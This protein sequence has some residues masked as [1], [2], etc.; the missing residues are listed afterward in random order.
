MCAD[1]HRLTFCSTLLGSVFLHLASNGSS[2]EVRRSTLTVLSTLA[3]KQPELVNHLVSSALTTRLS[4][5]APTRAAVNSDDVEI[6]TT[7]PES[8]F[9]PFLL[10]CSAFGDTVDQ[11]TREPLLVNLVV[12]GHH[13]A[14]GESLI[15]IH[16][17]LDSG[18]CSSIS[19]LRIK[20]T[21]D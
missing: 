6:K 1:N 18:N 2:T 4:I 14:V 12:L 5:P 3:S 16:S 17:I 8:R 20:T 15:A 7:K 21:M 10:T 19:R 9:C 11:A 13:P